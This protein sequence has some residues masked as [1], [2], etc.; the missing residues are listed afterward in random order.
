MTAILTL[1]IL[2]CGTEASGTRT[3]LIAFQ[4]LGT[5]KGLICQEPARPSVIDTACQAFEPI[6]YSRNDTDETKRQIRGHN[7]AW[8][9]LCKRE[10]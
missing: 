5:G 9:A 6:R 7:A 2:S 10:D 4:I 3:C 8:T 1:T